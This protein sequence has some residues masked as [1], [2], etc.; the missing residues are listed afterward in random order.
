MLRRPAVFPSRRHGFIVQ[1]GAMRLNRGL[2]LAYCTNIHRGETWAQTF[3][4]LKQFTLAVRDQVCP[5]APYGIGLRLS[6]QAARQ[7]T[8]G[9]T[10]AAF[11]RWLD[12]QHCYVFTINGFPYGAFHG[13]RVK[14]Q[15][16]TPDWTTRERL[17]YTNLLSDLLAKLLPEGVEGSVSTV[18]G[19]FKELIRQPDQARAVR[20][21][22]WRCV[23]H[24]ARLRQQTGKTLHLGLE[25]EPLCLLETTQETARFFDQM[26][27]ERPGHPNLAEHLGVTYDACHLAVEFEEPR[28]ALQCLRQ[29]SIRISK[30]HLSSALKVRPTPET[31]ERLRAFADEV[32]LHQVIARSR[33]GRLTRY[34][35]LDDALDAFASSAGG[36]RAAESEPRPSAADEWRVHFHIPLHHRP[37]AGFDSTCDHLQG[38]LDALQ[39]DPEMCSHLEMETYTWEVMPPDLKNRSVVDQLVAE[40]QWTLKELATRGLAP[41]SP[42][43]VAPGPRP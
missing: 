28:N 35:D 17:I 31:C 11:Q 39:E 36:N 34:R 24:L 33:D 9:A 7:L 30:M 4:A 38:V 2:H 8:S 25:P 16:Y 18:P 40:Y 26:R 1:C 20:E 14:E 6:N 41:T 32:Y 22:L 10:L 15:V 3:D 23:E 29:H 37:G 5:Q 21:N 12:A 43:A 13:Q 27:E 42:A 19:S